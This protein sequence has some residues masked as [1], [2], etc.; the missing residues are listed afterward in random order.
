MNILVPGIP[1][2]LKSIPKKGLTLFAPGKFFFQY[3]Q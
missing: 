1:H 3:I 2:T